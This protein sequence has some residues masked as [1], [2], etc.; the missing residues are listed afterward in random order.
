MTE[1]DGLHAF[2]CSAVAFAGDDILVAASADHFARQGAI[3][4]RPTDRE[5]PMV[6]VGGGLPRWLDGI[7]DTGNIAAR[8]S[9]VA[10]AD[11]GGNLFLSEDAG[12]TWSRGAQGLPPPSSVFIY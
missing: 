2:Y 1:R 7:A 6:P 3:Y 4:R 10:V 12:R 11:R 8:G 5:G 9:A